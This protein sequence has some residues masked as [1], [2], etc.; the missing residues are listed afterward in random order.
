MS[1]AKFNRSEER[2]FGSRPFNVPQEDLKGYS[3][4]KTYMAVP[5]F[6]ESVQL[7]NECYRYAFGYAHTMINRLLS[8]EPEFFDGHEMTRN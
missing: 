8:E 7:Q 5:E 6:K 1:D 4:S 2:P 3:N